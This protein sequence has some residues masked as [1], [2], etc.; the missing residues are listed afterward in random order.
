MSYRWYK[1][2]TEKVREAR[3]QCID[4]LRAHDKGQHD[5]AAAL[6]KTL[7][8][9]FKQLMALWDDQ[10]PGK[11]FP[12]SNDIER[13]LRIAERVDIYDLLTKDLFDAEEKA[14]TAFAAPLHLTKV[15]HMSIPSALMNSGQLRRTEGSI[16]LACFSCAMSLTLHTNHAT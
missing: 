13:H 4:I 11:G 14:L 3:R 10:F 15:V 8:R 12:N 9:S 2:F 5:A 1:E 7:A 6:S 16:F